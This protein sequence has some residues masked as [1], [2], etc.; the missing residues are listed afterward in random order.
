MVQKITKVGFYWH[1]ND[2]FS[3]IVQIIVKFTLHWVDEPLIL[4]AAIH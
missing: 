1:E 3:E 4:F 2:L